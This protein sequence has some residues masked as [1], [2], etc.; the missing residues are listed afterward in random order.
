MAP[1]ARRAM[2]SP[3]RA[4]LG[5]AASVAAMFATIALGDWQLR[6]AAE[7]DAIAGAWETARRSEPLQIRRAAD[8]AAIGAQLPRRVRVAGRFDHSRTVWLDNRAQAGRA[9]FL[10]LTPLVLPAVAERILVIR[11]WAPRDPADRA[12]VPD[13]GGPTGMVEIEG[14]AIAR[15]PRLFEFASGSQARERGPIRQNIDL[16]AMRNEL[17]VP[18]APFVV[19]QT[20]PLADSLQ[21]HLVA[22]ASGAGR[23]RAYAV[24][25]FALAGLCAVV[26]AGVG[27]HAYRQQKHARTT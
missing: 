24:Q 14:I 21:R 17:G 15:A 5:V 6:R 25:W 11:G 8:I 4:T 27:W 23:N 22:P 12:R 7:R 10:A 19:E 16:D 3:L 9:G 13:A 2:L 1:C 26:A 18:L 20:S